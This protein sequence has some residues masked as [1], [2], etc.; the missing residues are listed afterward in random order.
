MADVDNLKIFYS[1]M[2]LQDV[3]ITISN[4]LT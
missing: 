1:L 4:Y 3:Y 2:A